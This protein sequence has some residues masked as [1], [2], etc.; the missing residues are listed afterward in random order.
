MSKRTA[1]QK[2]PLKK[3]TALVMAV[4]V[5]CTVALVPAS[6]ASAATAANGT[7]AN[8]SPGISAHCGW[9]VPQTLCPPATVV[10][11]GNRLLLNRLG[12]LVGDPALHKSLNN[13]LAVAQ[14]ELTAGPWSVTDKTML[15]PSGDKHDYLSLAPYWWPTQ[16]MTPANPWGCPYIQKDGQRD[17]IVDSIPD[18]A[19]RGSAFS[20]IYDLSLAWYYTRDPRYAQRAELDVR[21]WFLDT[22]T[23]MNPNLNYSQGIPCQVDGR[24]IGIIEFSEAL[25]DVVDATAIL[26][27]GAPGWSRTDHGGMTD[28]YAAFLT[29]LRTSSNGS[30][31]AAQQNNHG[32]F[33]DM[34]CAALALSVGQRD[35]ARA[36]VQQ[37]E[38]KRINVQISASGSEPLEISRTRSWH[39]STF[40]LVALTR[41]A[42]VGRHV[43]VNLWHYKSPAGS[44]L[45]SAVDFLLPAAAGGKSAWPYPELSFQQDAA[46]DIV[47][48]AADAGDHQAR[49][50][51]PNVPAPSFGDLYPIA[52]A[53][54]QLDDI[55]GS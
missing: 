31:E 34:L 6:G 43:G 44:G 19:E 45:F 12:L 23:K 20:A 29:W 18:H 39:Y 28:W 42:Q 37:A 21:T 22:A 53:A 41:L 48:E 36:I 5:A 15:P 30:D 17:P 10:L 1:S 24:G 4:G 8:I 55:S 7:P 16:P 50:A 32:T 49:A 9:P 3:I 40:N 27:D 26:D 52:P 25:T 38:T 14:P 35:T 47:H 33:Y 11:D 54:E 2:A 51:L 13:L 46:L